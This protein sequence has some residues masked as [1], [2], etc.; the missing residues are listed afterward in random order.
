MGHMTS[1]KASYLVTTRA[2]LEVD[3]RDIHLFQAKGTFGV[4]LQ[5]ALKSLD[6]SL[7]YGL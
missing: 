2:W 6:G 3:V 4:L 1:A 5:H 7:A